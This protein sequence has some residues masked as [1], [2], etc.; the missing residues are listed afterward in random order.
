MQAV[1][2]S[3]NVSQSYGPIWSRL[4]STATSVRP[5]VRIIEVSP[6]DGLQNEKGVI[7][8]ETKASL[9]LK[10]SQHG[11]RDIEAGSFVSPKVKQMADTSNVLQ[12]AATREASQNA[13][14]S[15]LVP[16]LRG[17]ENLQKCTAGMNSNVVGEVSIF[18]AATEAFSNANL[19][20]SVSVALDRLGE[21]AEQA[22]RAGYR[23]R[24]YVSCIV[25]VSSDLLNLF[26][27]KY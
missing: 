2:N 8:T 12:H 20:A 27:V 19:N 9:I 10:L 26:L 4:H 17:F 16:N 22:K 25:G 13:N 1:R 23:I 3:R 11:F 6:R 18:A 5:G 14:F 24:G 21:V 15:V 7:D